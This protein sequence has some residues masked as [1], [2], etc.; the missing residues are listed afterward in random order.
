MVATMKITGYTTGM[1]GLPD[2]TQ[3]TGRKQRKRRRT[4]QLLPRDTVE[5]EE[6]WTLTRVTGPGLLPGS[7]AEVTGGGLHFPQQPPLVWHAVQLAEDSGHPQFP[8]TTPAL[9]AA[10]AAA[11]GLSWKRYWW[12]N[13]LAL[14]HTSCPSPARA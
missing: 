8:H 14:P 7:Q 9:A 13:Q 6:N 12:S 3:P 2:P 10:T 5:D 4:P 1:L 11:T